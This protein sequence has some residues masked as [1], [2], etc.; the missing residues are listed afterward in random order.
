M[1][2][3]GDPTH[4]KTLCAAGE[5]GKGAGSCSRAKTGLTGKAIITFRDYEKQFL[6]ALVR[7]ALRKLSGAFCPFFPCL[8]RRGPSR[9]L[10]KQRILKSLPGNF[11]RSHDLL[12]NQYKGVVIQGTRCS[13]FHPTLAVTCI[14]ISVARLCSFKEVGYEGVRPCAGGRRRRPGFG[15]SLKLC[16]CQ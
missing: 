9:G 10:H 12:P 16:A 2:A 5:N 1:D 14:P 3:S 6:C 4:G 15:R 11:Y 13:R 7:C 8:I